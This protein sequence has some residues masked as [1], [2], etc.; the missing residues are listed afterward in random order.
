MG[1]P[2]SW[3]QYLHIDPDTDYVDRCRLLST[4][5]FNDQKKL[6]RELYATLKPQRI[7]CLGS[8]C[9]NDIPI[10]QFIKGGSVVYLV[11]WIPDISEKGFQSDLIGKEGDNYS[12][13]FC[14]LDRDPLIF[15]TSF[16]KECPS[17]ESVCDNF[18]PSPGPA[19][20]CESYHPG[21]EPLFLNRDITSGRATAFAKRIALL[22]KSSNTP[23][24]AFRKALE[25][26]RRC[27][28]VDEKIPIEDHSL[29]LVTSSM[30]VS[31]FD[32][33][34]YG[35]FSKLLFQHFDSKILKE[36]ASLIP[37]MEELRSEFFQ[38]QI[39]GHIKELYRL[40]KK[41][42]GRVY[43]SVELFHSLS[44]QNELFMVHEIPKAMEELGRYFF[45]DFQAIP[46]DQAL[47][48][49]EKENQVSILTSF[50]LKPK[51]APF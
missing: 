12:C 13:L 18:T 10:D 1:T 29:D 19:V 51:E 15:C 9:L 49:I 40:V 33:E 27:H 20:R 22:V 32:H 48:K 43:F 31:Q 36:E 2:L 50:L 28:A 46:H 5:L 7:A 37:L 8:G 25:E 34:P 14:T 47:R 17:Q 16:Q 42:G 6:I 35:F 44:D 23:K 41:E 30:V 26:A 39:E 3:E 4:P 24:Q 38:I 21:S 45:F 11:D